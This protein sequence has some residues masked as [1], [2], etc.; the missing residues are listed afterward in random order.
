MTWRCSPTTSHSGARKRTGPCWCEV[1]RGR[2]S[3]SP[4]RRARCCARRRPRSGSGRGWSGTAVGVA[5]LRPR[6]RRRG[7]STAVTS[8]PRRRRAAGSG[9]EVRLED[10]L[11]RRSAGMHAGAGGAADRALGAGG[12]ARPRPPCPT[13]R[14]ARRRLQRLPLDVDGG[15]PDLLLEAPGAQQLHRRGADAGGAGEV[16]DLRAALDDERLDAR[17][18]EGD[19]RGQPRGP[20]ADDEDRRDFNRSDR[21]S[22]ESHDTFH[23]TRCP[24][25]WLRCPD[26]ST[27]RYQQRA[28]AEEA[29]KT[30][31]RIVEA[32]LARLRAAPSEPVSHR[33][34]RRRSPASR[35]RPCTRSSAR[36]P[37]CS[38][39]SARL[40]GSAAAIGGW[41]RRRTT[42]DAREALRGGL[43]AASEM[44]GGQ[45]DS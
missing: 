3:R 5:D 22:H 41:S 7:S 42:A 16:G 39:R 12:G 28:R 2:A 45:R 17:A 40:P 13:P 27:R 38:T 23:P 1:A 31:Q 32:V 19:G 21:V 25:K 9:R 6:R 11:E 36:A 35:A 34:D 26:V 4:V 20:G 29:G 8:T 24:V 10:R 44:L 18:G 14:A 37:G 15:R 43:R 33:A 30:R